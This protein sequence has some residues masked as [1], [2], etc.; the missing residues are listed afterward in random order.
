[1]I[2]AHEKFTMKIKIIS[3]SFTSWTQ[4]N[5]DII[6]GSHVLPKANLL[7]KGFLLLYWKWKRFWRADNVG[8]GL[9]KEEEEANR[10]PRQKSHYWFWLIY[11]EIS[12]GFYTLLFS[13]T[14]TRFHSTQLMYCDLSK[15]KEIISTYLLN[16]LKGKQRIE[17]QEITFRWQSFNFYHFSIILIQFVLDTKERKFWE[18]NYQN[19]FSTHFKENVENELSDVENNIDWHR[20]HKWFTTA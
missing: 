16:R 13:S 7:R 15:R 3:F 2:F 9:Q 6:L 5:N 11:D 8:D 20:V 18:R 1:M 17:R 4:L 14:A 10:Y 19:E 12:K